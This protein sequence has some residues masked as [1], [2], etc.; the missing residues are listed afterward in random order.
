MNLV[1]I[2]FCSFTIL[3]FSLM[4]SVLATS[5]NSGKYSIQ[6]TSELDRHVWFNIIV[7]GETQTFSEI[8][9]PTTGSEWL[10]FSASYGD[11]IKVEITGWTSSLPS[12][13]FSYVINNGP[14]GN[15]RLIYNSKSTTYTPVNFCTSGTCQYKIEGFNFDGSTVDVLVNGKVVIANFDGSAEQ[16]FSVNAGDVIKVVFTYVGGIYS[17]YFLW[18]GAR[19]NFYIYNALG[20]NAQIYSYSPSGGYMYPISQENVSEFATS[21][22]AGTQ[23]NGFIPLTL[24]IA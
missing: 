21:I 2:L 15:G 12:P 11:N 18:L 3:F 14:G 19:R 24:P 6:L 10:D 9:V 23:S 13:K 5:P 8:P 22:G 1:R 17:L 4:T 7:N 16:F 20:E